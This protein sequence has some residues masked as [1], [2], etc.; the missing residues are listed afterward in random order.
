M[1][2]YTS[3]YGSKKIF[4][5]VIITNRYACEISVSLHK[6]FYPWQKSTRW[7]TFPPIQIVCFCIHIIL[8]FLF[9]QVKVL[10]D[11][12]HYMNWEWLEFLFTT[13]ALY[14]LVC[15]FSVMMQQVNNNCSTGSTALMM[16]KQLVEGGESMQYIFKCK[17]MRSSYVQT[18]CTKILKIMLINHKLFFAYLIL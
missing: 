9:M 1:V 11:S 14:T 16:A 2:R 7:C 8:V 6:R 15:H 17:H 4:K 12:G 3:S 5:Q 18:F 10:V 13:W